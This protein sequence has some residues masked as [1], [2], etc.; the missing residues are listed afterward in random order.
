MG[1][2]GYS[3]CG[4]RVGIV[5]ALTGVGA[6]VRGEPAVMHGEECQCLL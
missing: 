4:F 5:K 6:K 2:G 1:V 3:S